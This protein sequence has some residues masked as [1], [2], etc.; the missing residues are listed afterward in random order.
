[1]KI[2]IKIHNKIDVNLMIQDLKRRVKVLYV[3]ENLIDICRYSYFERPDLGVG[4]MYSIS[5]GGRITIENDSIKYEVN[6]VPQ[7]IFSI[8]LIFIAIA[9]VSDYWL[10]SAAIVGLCLL[11]W[12]SIWINH[13]LFIYLV[14][15][16]SRI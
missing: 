9:L 13:R 4:G 14:I 7:I 15:R 6:V 11:I 5:P 16:N 2:T 3:A 8:M 12:L 1:M 10:L